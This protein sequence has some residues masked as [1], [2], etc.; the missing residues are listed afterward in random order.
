MAKFKCEY[1]NGHVLVSLKNW[2]LTV[3]ADD[4]HQAY[5][6]FIKE[7]GI[8]NQRVYVWGRLKGRY[9][10]DH[11]ISEKKQLEKQQKA[12]GDQRNKLAKDS[13]VFLE[14]RNEGG[15]FL[16]ETDDMYW[17]ANHYV[18]KDQDRRD[19]LLSPMYLDNIDKNLEPIYIQTPK[20]KCKTN[21]K[22]I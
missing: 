1:E 8:Y 22:E 11:V 9:F 14:R 21:T 20:L 5:V 19:P 15:Y 17:F 10:E 4:A 3:E 13:C 6:K 16:L 18:N 2:K 12:Q 7:L